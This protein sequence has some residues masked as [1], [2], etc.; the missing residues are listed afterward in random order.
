MRKLSTTFRDAL[1]HGFLK[2]LT[3]TVRHDKDLD[4]QIRHNYINIYYKGHALLKLM[5]KHPTHYAITIHSAFTQGVPLLPLIDDAT[6]HTFVH[7]I[8]QLK[9]NIIQYRTSSLELEYEQ[10]FIRANNREARNTV[11]Y[12]LIDRQYVMGNAR[13][14]LTGLFWD[15]TQRKPYQ[16]VTPCLM[17]VKFALNT[18]I[19]TIHRQIDRYYQYVKHHSH[20]IA[21]E[22]ETLFHQ[23]LALGLYQQE[24]Q[25]LEMMKTLRI[26]PHIDDFQFLIILVDYNPNSQLFPKAAREQLPFASQIRIFSSGFAM[27]KENIN[28]ISLDTKQANNP[29]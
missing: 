11:E 7:A 12:F 23:K 25:R 24:Q 5:E 1:Q 6:T 10:L 3:E 14:D 9:A 8:P 18:D 27:W 19:R 20:A 4:L 17:E 26:A 2:A 21:A 16:T 22:M 13:F 29:V 28:H 15:R